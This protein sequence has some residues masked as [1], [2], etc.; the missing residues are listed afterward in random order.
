MVYLPKTYLNIKERHPAFIAAVESLGE[1]T[2][3]A[4][5]LDDKTAQLIQL[6]AAA[7]VYSEGSVKSHA[8]RAR[9]AGAS[10]EEIAHALILLTSTIGFPTV[11]AALSWVEIDASPAWISECD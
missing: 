10:E 2:A 8:R 7:A 6:A 11:A 4:G 3:Q 1:V 9:R 5:P